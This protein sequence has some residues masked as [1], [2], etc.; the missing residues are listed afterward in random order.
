MQK[1]PFGLYVLA[2]LMVFMGLMGILGGGLLAMRPDGSLMKIPVSDLAPTIFPD[3]LIP[4]LMLLIIIG[5]LPML[6]TYAL[7]ARPNSNILKK[8]NLY[9]DMDWPWA[10][11]VYYGFVVILWIVIE[12][13]LIGYHTVVQSAVSVWG[14]AIVALA[15]TPRVRNYFKI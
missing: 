7:F 6:L 5:I 4:G 10:W 9:S 11:A 15:L 1:R 8:L 14:V 12:I 2:F 13:T 3:F